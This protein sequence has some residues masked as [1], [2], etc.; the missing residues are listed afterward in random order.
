[1]NSEASLSILDTPR[2]G[3]A[4]RFHPIQIRKRMPDSASAGH[5]VLYW[6]DRRLAEALRP[7]RLDAC[8]LADPTPRIIKRAEIR[9][10]VSGVHPIPRRPPAR[11]G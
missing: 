10:E 7:C 3:F 9:A 6:T 8:E 11:A 2:C 5:L 4:G 1:M